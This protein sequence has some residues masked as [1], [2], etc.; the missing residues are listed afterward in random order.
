MHYIGMAAMKIEP[1]IH[2]QAGLFILHPYRR[3]RPGAALWMAF[4]PATARRALLQQG[5]PS[6]RH[7]GAIIGMH[8]TGMAAAPFPEGSLC[9]APIPGSIPSGWRPWSS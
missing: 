2:Y 3:A 6:P 5:S 1:G 7:G 9:G 4:P 8:Y